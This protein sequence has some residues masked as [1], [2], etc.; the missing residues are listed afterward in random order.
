MNV[1]GIRVIL[2]YLLHMH[3]FTIKVTIRITIS[4]IEW[5]TALHSVILWAESGLR[6]CNND[7]STYE[8]HHSPRAR[9]RS[10]S[11]TALFPGAFLQAFSSI[12]FYTMGQMHAWCWRDRNHLKD[13]S[14]R[15]DQIILEGSADRLRYSYITRTDSAKLPNSAV[16]SGLVK[17][18][19]S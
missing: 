3:H 14:K 15:R 5:N 18:L 8:Q 12:S 1:S 7:I 6:F 10:W 16:N 19:L 9:A 13:R 4:T 11:F 2:K 17:G